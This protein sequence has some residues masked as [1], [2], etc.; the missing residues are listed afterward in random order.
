MLR[1]ARLLRVVKLHLAE[2]AEVAGFG[3]V[4]LTHFPGFGLLEGQE[5]QLCY[6]SDVDL[7][8]LR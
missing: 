2:V 5:V 6:S 8:G 1:L 3:S 7:S 4:A